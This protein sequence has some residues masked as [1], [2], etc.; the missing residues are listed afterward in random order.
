MDRRTLQEEEED[1]PGVTRIRVGEAGMA[2]TSLPKNSFQ[3]QG[4]WGG[5]S[6]QQ[7]HCLLICY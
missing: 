1:S 4:A 5:W 6:L 3:E 2:L 7:N